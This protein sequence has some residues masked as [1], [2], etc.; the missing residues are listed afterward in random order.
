MFLNLSRNSG[1]AQ[2]ASADGSQGI[3]PKSIDRP[4]YDSVKQFT[5]RRGPGKGGRRLSA[6]SGFECAFFLHPHQFIGFSTKRD[7]IF[8]IHR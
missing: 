7:F 3:R 4:G 8:S 2:S 6:E 5:P 1:P